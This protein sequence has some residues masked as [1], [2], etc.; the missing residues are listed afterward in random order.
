MN[1]IDRTRPTTTRILAGI[2]TWA[3]IAG[4]VMQPVYAVL[5]NLADSAIAAKVSAKP[6]IVYTL[7]DSGSMSLNYVPDYVVSTA[8]AVAV[9]KITRVGAVATVQ[10]A[11]TGALFVG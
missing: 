1:H 4:Q 5:T 10:V 7:D 2:L 8:P 9:T 3:L 11:A 6:N